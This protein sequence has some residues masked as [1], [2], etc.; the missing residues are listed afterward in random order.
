MENAFYSIEIAQQLGTNE[1]QEDVV[2]FELGDMSAMLILCDG[3]GGMQR[4]ELAAKTAVDAIKQLG[5]KMDWEHNPQEFLNKAIRVADEEV[6]LLTDENGERIRGGCTLILA[7][8]IGRNLYWANVGDSRIYLYKDKEL[9][10]LT[11]DHNYGEMLKRRL[12][13]GRISEQELKNEW[14]RA[15][16]LTSYIGIG[17]IRE[18][19]ISEISVQMDRDSVVLMQS[20]GLY[21][22]VS[23]EEMK[24]VIENSTRNLERVMTK[25]LERAY[26]NKK[27]YQDNTSVILLRMK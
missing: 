9:N 20:D 4:G 10:Q 11:Q 7:L 25:L 3:M 8:V 24:G 16:A 14:G 27:E 18:E 22:L 1:T 12:Q 6:Y 5:K 23:E 17:E 2:G 19:Y 15:A 26:L 13:Q 21:K